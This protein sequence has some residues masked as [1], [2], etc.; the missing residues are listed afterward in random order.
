MT[1]T[2]KSSV[3]RSLQSDFD[4]TKQ[5]NHKSILIQENF[6]EISTVYHDVKVNIEHAK[7]LPA[8]YS[9]PK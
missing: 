7:S 9:G 3:K 8:V 1:D 2:V 5:T 6:P 4:N